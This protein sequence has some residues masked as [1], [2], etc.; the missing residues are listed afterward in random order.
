VYCTLSQ[1]CLGFLDKREGIALMVVLVP[2]PEDVSRQLSHK[3]LIA[4]GNARA[5][6]IL[7]FLR[8]SENKGYGCITFICELL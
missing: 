8:Q 3:G 2:R 4:S 7:S 6:K 5:V 1:Y